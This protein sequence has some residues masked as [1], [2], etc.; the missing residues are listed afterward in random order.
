MR[1]FQ[2]SLLAAALVVA[3]VPGPVGAQDVER[4]EPDDNLGWMVVGPGPVGAQNVERPPVVTPPDGALS[5]GEQSGACRNPYLPAPASTAPS[6]RGGGPEVPGAVRNPYLPAPAG[7]ALSGRGG[8]SEAPSPA[9]VAPG[10]AGTCPTYRC[11]SMS[12]PGAAASA[13]AVLPPEAPT[14]S[15]AQA[16]PP[17]EAPAAAAAPAVLPPAAPAATIA[18]AL[19][20]P[21]VAPAAAV[22]P[23]LP[24]PAPVPPG[25]TVAAPG[26][27]PPVAPG[28][29]PDTPGPPDQAGPHPAPPLGFWDRVRYRLQDWCLGFP[30]E[31]RSPPLGAFLYEHF[32]TEV[33]NGDAARMVLYQYDFVDGSDVLNHHGQEKLARIAALLPTNFFPVVIEALPCAPGLAEARRVVVLNLLACGPFPI[34]PER[35][36]IGPPIAAGLSGREAELVYQNLLIQTQRQGVLAGLGGGS[37]GGTV[38][39]GFS[40]SGRNLAGPGGAGVP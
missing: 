20:P 25:T 21:A 3:A 11:H 36:V 26:L 8:G 5:P 40:A 17:P 9:A 15:A 7:T 19:P 2:K 14:T 16:P 32:K 27:P 23:V 24:P 30:E 4:P 38:G 6:G 29:A 10:M 34:P 18:P 39:Q 37:I 31:F 13:P 1:G 22:A 28:G 35:V 12:M 33:A